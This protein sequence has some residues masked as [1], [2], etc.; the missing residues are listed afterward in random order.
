MI[1]DLAVDAHVHSTVSD[2]RDD[3]ATNVAVAVSRD[4]HTLG[5]VDHVR[6]DTTWVQDYVE[7]VDR[8]N[9]TSPILVTAGIEAK[10]LGTSGLLDMPSSIQGIDSIVAADHQVPL[11][12]ATY[13]PAEIR[14]R[15]NSGHLDGQEVIEN[16][17]EATAAA[18]ARYDNVLIAHLFSVLPKCGLS[19]YMVSD[20]QVLTLGRHLAAAG[21]RVEISERWRCPSRRVAVL[22]ATAGVELVASTRQSPCRLDRPIRPCRPSRRGGC[23]GSRPP[24]ADVDAAR[25]RGA[26]RPARSV[27]TR[28]AGDAWCIAARR[29][30]VSVRHHWC[31]RRAEPL[32]QG[33]ATI[34]PS[35]H[36]DPRLERGRRHRRLDRPAAATRLP[37]GTAS[38]LRRRRCQHRRNTRCRDR[39]GRGTSRSGHPPA[40]RE[41]R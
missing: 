25:V 30:V 15:I 13:V 41:R 31:A 20:D 1:M 36:P 16:I 34:P 27:D 5:L 38:H 9:R 29:S 19:E 24:C 11:G 10:L 40:S 14:D 22:L 21:A 28:G 26:R 18:A 7:V 17:L 37:A 2:G 6:R 39:Q 33:R 32:R 4:L 35:R 3:P 12:E 23:F 8:L